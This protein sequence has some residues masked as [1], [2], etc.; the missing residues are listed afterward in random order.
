MYAQVE[1]DFPK[2][3]RRVDVVEFPELVLALSGRL[4]DRFSFSY[5]YPFIKISE[6]IFKNLKDTQMA[7][8]NLIRPVRKT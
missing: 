4:A 5:T 1:F 2:L 8:R 3:N 7:A 6:E